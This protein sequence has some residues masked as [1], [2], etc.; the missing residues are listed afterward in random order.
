MLETLPWG[1][2]CAVQ[3]ENYRFN[4]EDKKLFG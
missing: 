2:L 3:V 1:F 4:E